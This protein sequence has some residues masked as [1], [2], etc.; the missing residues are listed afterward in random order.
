MVT[1]WKLRWQS[2]IDQSRG[3]GAD[4]P[5]HL[6]SYWTLPNSPS[7]TLPVRRLNTFEEVLCITNLFFCFQESTTEIHFINARNRNCQQESTERIRIIKSCRCPVLPDGP[8]IELRMQISPDGKDYRPSGDLGR[9]AVGA[10]AAARVPVTR[11]DIADNIV[12]GCIYL[13]TRVDL[14]EVLWNCP[15]RRTLGG[16][17][18]IDRVNWIFTSTSSIICRTC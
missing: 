3:V 2:A 6:H 4:G 16:E 8:K 14:L 11:T 18:T 10:L 13:R 12:K 9:D 7:N 17:V 1:G 15:C 5:V